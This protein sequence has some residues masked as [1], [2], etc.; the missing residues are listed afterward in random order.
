MGK[1]KKYYS[2][3]EGK[4]TKIKIKP[5]TRVAV[6]AD[7]TFKKVIGYGTYLKEERGDIAFEA[8][9][10][11][12]PREGLKSPNSGKVYHRE[13]Y[14][15]VTNPKIR[16]DNGEIVYGYGAWWVP[17]KEKGGEKIFVHDHSPFAR[18][19]NEYCGWY[20]IGKQLTRYDPLSKKQ[21]QA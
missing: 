7:E 21:V 1:R 13:D 17:L 14:E 8:T 10:G 16:L 20:E 5:G 9:H 15:K 19:C 18:D 3:I 6:F 4:K 2:E 11:P 12:I